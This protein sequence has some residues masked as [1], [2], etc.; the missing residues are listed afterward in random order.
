MPP[1]PNLYHGITFR[2]KTS[3]GWD[4]LVLPSTLEG[5]PYYWVL[6]PLTAEQREKQIRPEANGLPGKYRVV[7][8]LAKPGY[9]LQAAG[10]HSTDAGI[11]GDSNLYIGRD[12]ANGHVLLLKI[13]GRDFEVRLVANS[14]GRLGKFVL[15]SIQADGF[16]QARRLAW[17]AV[18]PTLSLLS[19]TLDIPLHISQVDL[20]E[21]RSHAVA[22]EILVDHIDV[23]LFLAALNG[24]SDEFRHYAS[25][26]REA[27]NS[28]SP[29]YE[30]LCLFKIIES[31]KSRRERL[32]REAKIRGEE[33]RRLAERFPHQSDLIEWLDSL[34]PPTAKRDWAKTNTAHTFPMEVFGKRFGKIIEDHLRP[35]RVRIAH[36]LL[37]TGELGTSIDDLEE[38]TQVH[39][40]MP[41][42]KY[43]VRQMLKTE[44]PT[45]YLLDLPDSEIQNFTGRAREIWPGKFPD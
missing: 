20:T 18:S 8:T 13:D 28:N 29:N 23:G 33:P 39:Q 22:G 31:I 27:L 6:H 5:R 44:F 40:W 4:T 2:I 30:F 9:A 19:A 16:P 26:Y 7:L 24:L 36:G 14:H 37:D 42:T 34:L 25:M 12:F 32:A 1:S 11:E 10:E 43:L 35:L 17:A 15:D 21:L 45:E 41:A 38:I 3:L